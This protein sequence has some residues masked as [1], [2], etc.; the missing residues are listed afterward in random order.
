MWKDVDSVQASMQK[1]HVSRLHDAMRSIGSDVTDAE[2][3][4]SKHQV[5]ADTQAGADALEQWSKAHE[6]AE[7]PKFT[8]PVIHMD[9]TPASSIPITDVS[10]HEKSGVEHWKR[11]G[12]AWNEASQKENWRTSLKN[13]HQSDVHEAMRSIGS[14]VPDVDTSSVQA[15][16]T[17]AMKT[18]GADML[19]SWSKA[20][21]KGSKFTMPAP[22]AEEQMPMASPAVTQKE[23][24]PQEPAPEQKEDMSTML[25]QM[26]QSAVHEAMRN[27]GSGMPDVSTEPSSSLAAT[28]EQVPR[29]QDQA[30]TDNNGQGLIEGWSKDHSEKPKQKFLVDMYPPTA[31]PETDILSLAMA[32]GFGQKASLALEEPA[33]KAGKLHA[34]MQS[35]AGDTSSVSEGKQEAP[36]QAAAVAGADILSKWSK[37]H[38]TL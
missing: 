9:P 13:W 27:I 1:W 14:G 35:M 38:S 2:P 24:T 25:K 15:Q 32:R 19:A 16:P 23:L 7:R 6:K 37:T 21:S 3:A 11:M 20:H 22:Q 12:K 28:P 34:A 17:D 18:A 4:D 10:T 5:P 29:A 33:A 36:S 26:K 8:M 30:T 31:A